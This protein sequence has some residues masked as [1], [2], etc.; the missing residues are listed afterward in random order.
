MY[1]QIQCE[2]VNW[3]QL[4]QDNILRALLNVVMNVQVIW[5]HGVT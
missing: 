1:P 5:K 2:G 3:I 4:T